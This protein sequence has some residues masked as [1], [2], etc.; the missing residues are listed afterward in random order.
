MFCHNLEIHRS[1]SG[2]MS[3]IEIHLCAIA[4]IVEVRGRLSASVASS[5]LVAVT[6]STILLQTSQL[7]D[8]EKSAT[9]ALPSEKFYAMCLL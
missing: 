5:I 1:K 8:E 4:A 2:I 9:S 6:M 7:N 3:G